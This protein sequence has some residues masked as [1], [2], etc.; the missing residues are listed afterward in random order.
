MNYIKDYEGE[1]YYNYK[2]QQKSN[3]TLNH[4]KGQI[5]ES[6]A[7]SFLKNK[8]YEILETNYRNKIGEIDIIAQ[9]DNRIIFVEVKQRATARFGYPREAVTNQKQ[10]KIRLVSQVY[11][12]LKGKAN[13]FTRYDVIEI[14]GDEITHLENAF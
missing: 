3:K 9:K 7:V 14:L 2:T 6:F 1:Q 8:G 5:G 10:H 11:L 13:A 12:K 4:Q